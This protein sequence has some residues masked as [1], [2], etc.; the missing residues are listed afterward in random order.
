MRRRARVVDCDARASVAMVSFG[1]G[2]GPYG[3]MHAPPRIRWV[4]ARRAYAQQLRPYL[5]FDVI[6]VS[7]VRVACG[8]RGGRKP[9]LP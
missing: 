6:R 8:E 2:G 5:I 4:P 9:R 1:A 3:G 7:S